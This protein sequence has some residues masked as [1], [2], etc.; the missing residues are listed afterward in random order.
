MEKVYLVWYM[1]VLE[2]VSK[3]TWTLKPF[4]YVYT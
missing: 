3:I 2:M 1:I 4:A